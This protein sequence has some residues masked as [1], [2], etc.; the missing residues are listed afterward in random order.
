[1]RHKKDGSM[2]LESRLE[3]SYYKKI[4]ELNPEHGIFVVQNSKNGKVF[5]KKIITVYN[6]DVYRRLMDA[7]LPGM[8]RIYAL[9][10]EDGRLTVIEEYISGSTLA[11]LFIEGR[12]FEPKEIKRIII[13]LCV[14]IESLHKLTPPVIHRDIKP[15]NVMITADNR[16]ILLDMNAARYADNT[17]CEDTELLGTKG[18]AAPEQYG[19]GT[20]DERTDIYAT[21][22]L[23][24]E[25]LQNNYMENPAER[26]LLTD[27]ADK[28]TELN[29]RDRFS[30]IAELRESL[31][32]VDKAMVVRGSAAG[33]KS[34]IKSKRR[35][36]P[37]GFRTLNPFKMAV[38]IAGYLSVFILSFSFDFETGSAAALY[39]ERGITLLM[40]LCVI[41][42]SC[43]YLGVQRFF[44]LCKSE[45]KFTHVLGIVLADISIIGILLVIMVL[46]EMALKSGV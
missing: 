44:P 18:Y 38:A 33:D 40:M 22:M 28:C 9:H 42:F 14:T 35:L 32:S 26:S 6:P 3:I 20:S 8:P 31:S 41:F 15:S 23:I 5:V 43:N 29:P 10:E 30:S 4:A 19:F 27:V 13:E 36:L 34:A 16:V 7:G 21:G 45:K 37:P 1:M 39:I 24:K 46:I 2:N 11:E 25:L 17:K 12:R